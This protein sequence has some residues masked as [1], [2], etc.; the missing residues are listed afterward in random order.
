MRPQEE[1]ILEP[2]DERLAYLIQ[3]ELGQ[4]TETRLD[5]LRV[6]VDRGR[7]RITGVV[8]TPEEKDAILEAAAGVP[9]VLEVDDAIA[10]DLNATVPNGV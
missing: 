1:G 3:H 9:G 4:L 8:P 10:V 7:A 5:N 2:Q 6:S